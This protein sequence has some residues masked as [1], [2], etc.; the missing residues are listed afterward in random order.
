M[1]H[2]AN[3][4][5]PHTVTE[6]FTFEIP[7]ASQPTILR[8]EARCEGGEALLTYEMTHFGEGVVYRSMAYTVGGG[9]F[10]RQEWRLPPSLHGTTI[11]A[12]IAVPE[13]CRLI[14]RSLESAPSDLRVPWNGGLRLNAHLGFWG[15]CPDNTM[16]AFELAAQCGYP[17]CIVVPKPTAD[18]DLVCIHDDTINRTARDAAGNPPDHPMTVW[19][20]TLDELCRWEVGSYKH[21]IW[22][23]VK[24]PRL[25]EFFAL[26]ARTGMRPMFSTHPALT[27]GQWAQVKELLRRYGLTGQ[28]HVKS[29]GADVLAKAWEVF[30]DTIEGYTY[31]VN[32]RSLDIPARIAD[33][34]GTG[35]E[36][37]KVRVGIEL[38]QADMTEERARMIL[39]AGCFASVWNV[40]RIP[41]ARYR[42]LMAMGVTEVTDDFNCS[43]G[44]NW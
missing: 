31:D 40:G 16:P 37:G 15:L 24:I 8:A 17:A 38:P 25:E 27:D 29:F 11:T 19:E 43:Y 39:D 9:E 34:A 22:R 2:L 12:C 33:L 26:C 14:L 42:E 6:R 28:F 5:T 44:L 18:G 35:I 13:G 10:T 3:F 20:M 41:A 32:S 21:P 1:I 36:R 7:P 30:G 4:I 23:G